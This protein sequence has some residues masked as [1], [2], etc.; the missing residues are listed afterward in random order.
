MAGLWAAKIMLLLVWSMVL[1]G[2]L[3]VVHV[4]ASGAV[5]I[6]VGR[7]IGGLSRGDQWYGWWEQDVL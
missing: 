1:D 3:G 4:L 6:G 2:A 5:A 7:V